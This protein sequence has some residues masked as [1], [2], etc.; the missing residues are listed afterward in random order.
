MVTI[1]SA[2]EEEHCLAYKEA[3]QGK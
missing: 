1:V 2:M 3:P